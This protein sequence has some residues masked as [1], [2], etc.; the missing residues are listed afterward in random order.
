LT[1]IKELLYGK[2]LIQNEQMVKD[3]REGKYKNLGKTT[4]D[5]WIFIEIDR[6]TI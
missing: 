1:I 2:N 3:L 5:A 4:K 6:V